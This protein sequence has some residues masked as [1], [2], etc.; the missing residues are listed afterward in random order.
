MTT[1]HPAAGLNLKPSIHMAVSV[2]VGDVAQRTWQRTWQRKWRDVLHARQALVQTYAGHRLD[3]DDLTRRV[4]CFFK[5]CHE[6][7]DWIEESTTLPAKLYAKQ[8][9]TLDVCD[10]I[11]QTAK[12][13]ERRQSG[14]PIS[15]VVVTLY[16]DEAGIHADVEWNDSAGRNGRDDALKLADRCIDEWQKFFQ[17][18][19]LDPNA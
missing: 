15:A 4:E 3:V 18:N 1:D 7:G 16:A 14:N 10:A 19:N 11:A 5:T 2:P 12:H 9:P 17:G 8:P 13:F 6:L